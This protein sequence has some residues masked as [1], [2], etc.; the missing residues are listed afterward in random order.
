MYVK[1]T[2]RGA[3]VDPALYDVVWTN[4]TKKGKATVVIRGKGIDTGNGIAVGSK[5]QPINIKAMALKGKTLEAYF[6]EEYKIREKGTG[7][8]L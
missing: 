8:R 5:N 6:R 3:V 2:V 7:S 1:V 4:A